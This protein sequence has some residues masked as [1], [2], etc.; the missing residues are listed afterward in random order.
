[1]WLGNFIQVKQAPLVHS[2]KVINN[3]PLNEAFNTLLA[4]RYAKN[5]SEWQSTEL[6]QILRN[7]RKDGNI[8]KNTKHN[9]APLYPAS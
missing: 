8:E 3:E 9:L 6:H 7:I 1:L 2:L 5:Q 4:S